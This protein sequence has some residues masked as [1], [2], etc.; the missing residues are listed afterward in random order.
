MY[1]SLAM[2]CWGRNRYEGHNWKCSSF[3]QILCA[4]WGETSPLCWAKIT[5]WQKYRK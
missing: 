3:D 1:A 2:N 4:H 5:K